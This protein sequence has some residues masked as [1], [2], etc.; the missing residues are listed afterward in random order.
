MIISKVKY[1]KYDVNK[2]EHIVEF[3]NGHIAKITSKF[4]AKYLPQ[5]GDYYIINDDG[6]LQE[7][8]D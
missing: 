4:A 6:S 1:T 2:K 8:K 7:F 5:V 3:E